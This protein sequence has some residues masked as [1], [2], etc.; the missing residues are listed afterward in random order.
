MILLYQRNYK[1]TLLE[2]RIQVLKMANTKYLYFNTMN[3]SY[4]T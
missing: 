3:L 1:K 4:N 2:I